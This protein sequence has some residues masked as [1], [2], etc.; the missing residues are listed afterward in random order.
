MAA[1]NDKIAAL[2]QGALA[3]QHLQ[4]VGV[5]VVGNRK[6]T[7][8]V[9]AERADGTSPTLDECA[10]A[11]RVLAA[12]LDVADY[13]SSAYILEVSSPGLERPLF[14]LADYSRFEGK[15][16]RISFKKPQTNP[17]GKPRGAATGILHQVTETG[18]MLQLPDEAEPLNIPFTLIQS[19][20]LEPTADEM[21]QLMKSLKT[22]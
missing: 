2:A 21:K 8:Q 9:L 12:Q 16:A 19:A 7:V 13:I 20:H 14:T 10:A 5:V 17:A 11:S 22:K 3:T 6:L 1:L 4:L 15:N 18:I